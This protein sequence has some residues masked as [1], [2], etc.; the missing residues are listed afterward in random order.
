MIG[1][2]TVL[3]FFRMLFLTASTLLSKLAQHESAISREYSEEKLIDDCLMTAAAKANKDFDLVKK[4][5]FPATDHI[6]WTNRLSES[7]FSHMKNFGV[8]R[9]MCIAER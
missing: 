1:I 2:K 8:K 7:V 9:T 5:P 3:F 6:V 4:L